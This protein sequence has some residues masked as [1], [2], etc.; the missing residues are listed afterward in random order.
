MPGADVAAVTMPVLDRPSER[1]TQISS[2]SATSLCAV[3]GRQSDATCPGGKT[4]SVAESSKLV[5]R[6]RSGEK[7]VVARN[8]VTLVG[9]GE[10]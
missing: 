8:M 9:T 3:S 5:I 7:E 4:A 1:A 10:Q 2:G 6:L